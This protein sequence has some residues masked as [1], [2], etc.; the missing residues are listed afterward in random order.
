MKK[1]KKYIYKDSD[2]ALLKSELK[3][4][5]CCEICN[6]NTWCEKFIF[7][8]L[9]RSKKFRIFTVSENQKYHLERII[10]LHYVRHVDFLS[11]NDTNIFGETI[12]E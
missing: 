4:I 12:H 10:S 11:S 9:N 3:N 2:L 1:N 6:E 7:D 8:M 5:E